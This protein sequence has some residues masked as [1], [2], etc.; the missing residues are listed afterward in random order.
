[1]SSQISLKAKVWDPVIAKIDSPTG[2]Q[3]FW[4]SQNSGMTP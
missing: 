4:Q 1:M 3:I 2:F